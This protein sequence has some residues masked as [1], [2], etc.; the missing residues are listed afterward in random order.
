NTFQK[1][2]LGWLNYGSSPPITTVTTSGTYILE[3]Y[4]WASSGPKALKILKS[5]DATTGA[6]TWY[7]VEARQAIG[8]DSF[9]ATTQNTV[10]I[11]S[12]IQNGALVSLGTDGNGNSS[13]LL[14]MSPATE[15]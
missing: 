4:E 10:G 1:E 12:T 11:A 2:R 5:T 14:D 13:G 7:Y 6:K 8:F 15:T 3:A 9:L